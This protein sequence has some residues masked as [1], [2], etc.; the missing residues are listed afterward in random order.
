M[1]M[2]EEGFALLAL[3]WTATAL[4][5]LL[6]MGLLPSFRQMWISRHVATTPTIAS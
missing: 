4:T 2:A 6:F 5:V 3:S 1:R